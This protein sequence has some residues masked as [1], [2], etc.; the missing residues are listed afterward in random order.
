MLSS[1]LVGSV[2]NYKEDMRMFG[3]W[4]KSFANPTL[5]YKK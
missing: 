2:G 3:A 5:D 4:E 1:R